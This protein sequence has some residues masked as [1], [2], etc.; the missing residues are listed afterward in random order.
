MSVR[1]I[2]PQQDPRRRVA[3]ITGANKGIGKEVAR[4]LGLQGLLVLLGARNCGAGA[5]AVE[6]LRATGI[7]AHLVEIDICDDI[8]VQAARDQVSATHGRLD[9]LVNN[10]GILLEADFVKRAQGSKEFFVAPSAVAPDL[11]ARTFMTNFFGAVRVT[12]AF[13]PLLRRSAAA[14]I[15]NVSSHLA[16]MSGAKNSPDRHLVL[17]AYN[18]SKAALNS[19][20][21]QYAHELRATSIKINAVDPGHCA[22]DINGNMGDRSAAQAAQVIVR[23]ATLTDAGPS[24]EFHGE[25]GTIPW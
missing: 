20:T 7:D 18:A 25:T 2:E 8:S 17:L 5:N 23:F 16:S 1:A 9:V 24:G 12:N 11:L 22:T 6:E 14:R 21:V 13:L 4:Q 15:V 10:A 3:L 19:A